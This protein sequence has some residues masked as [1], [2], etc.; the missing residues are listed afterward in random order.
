MEKNRRIAW[1]HRGL[2]W[3]YAALTVVLTAM[4]IEQGGP[5]AA[6]GLYVAPPV[7]AGLFLLHFLI[8]RGVRAGKPGA[9]VASIV[10]ATIMLLVLPIGTLLGIFL[11]IHTIGH[12]E[13]EHPTADITDR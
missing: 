8:A 10:V 3:F 6:I 11:L 7:F 9:R 5:D 13:K 4:M 1:V 12:W 2:S